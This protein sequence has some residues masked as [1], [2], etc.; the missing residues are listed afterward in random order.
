MSTNSSILA[1]RIE[2]AS[3]ILAAVPILKDKN[4][5]E[6][7]IK[8]LEKQGVYANDETSLDVMIN[9]GIGNNEVLRDLKEE[10]GEKKAGHGP[11]IV[12]DIPVTRLN[13]AMSVLYA[14]I[15]QSAPSGNIV[16]DAKK[17]GNWDN[18]TLVKNYSPECEPK[19]TETLEKR[20]RGKAFVIFS[21]EK[22]NEINVEAT[23]K[24]L[25]VATSGKDTPRTYPVD[26]A[27]KRLYK[28]GEFPSTTFFECPLHPG[29][30][31]VVDGYCDECNLTWNTEQYEAMQ[32]VRLAFLAGHI[33]LVGNQMFLE[34]L[35]SKCNEGDLAWLKKSFAKVALD[36]EERK[37]QGTLPN[38]KRRTAVSNRGSDPLNV[39]KRY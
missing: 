37:E 28:A 24:M 26:G 7:L 16:H 4:V 36:F 29:I 38:L 20:S 32:F 19:I 10:L 31:L 34:A 3:N 33:P 23:L 18:E 14:P 30:M 9:G 5:K 2:K 27:L 13:A 35:N 39:N 22:A 6:A 21:N 11:A 15:T 17:P 12:I 8:V 25:K 1:D